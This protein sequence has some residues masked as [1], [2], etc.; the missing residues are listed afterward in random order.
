MVRFLLAFIT[1]CVFSESAFSQQLFFPDKYD[2]A[3]QRSVKRWWASGPEWQW[4]KAQLYQESR[5]DPCAVSPVGATGLAQFMP[6]TWADMQ[7]QLALPA[8]VPASH[9]S[10]AIDA[11]AYYMATLKR[12]W[13]APRPA[14][15]RHYLAQASYNAGFGNLV[16]AQRLCGGA[17]L[18]GEIVTC[19]PQVTGRHSLETITYVRRIQHWRSAMED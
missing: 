15:D 16:K 6:A 9:A 19:L 18:Y 3:I 4:W 7:R 14:M 2:E 13:S 1:A 11:G 17:A 12:R 10:Y 5:L 8:T